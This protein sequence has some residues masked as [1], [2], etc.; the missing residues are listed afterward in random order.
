MVARLQVHIVDTLNLE[1]VTIDKVQARTHTRR[2]QW[3]PTMLSIPQMYVVGIFVRAINLRWI[4]RHE[5]FVAGTE[6]RV[7]V[8]FFSL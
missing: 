6:G 2:A 1:I 8:L 7:A 5:C 4:V 3:R